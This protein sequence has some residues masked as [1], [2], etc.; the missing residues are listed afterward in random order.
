MRDF[1]AQSQVFIS[2]TLVLLTSF[3]LI[4]GGCS[5]TSGPNS[6]THPTAIRPPTS[7]WDGD[8]IRYRL[9]TH[10]LS[11]KGVP[12]KEGGYNKH[13]VDCS[14][15]VQLVFKNALGLNIPRSTNL[16]LKTGTQI[17]RQQLSVGDLVFFK[18]G[19]SKHHVG[20]Y[21]GKDQF[22]HASTSQGV[23]KS[24]LKSPY[25]S[26]HYWKATRVLSI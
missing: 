19:I 22:I 16:L 1:Q 21:I 11:W 13:G 14:G 17:S 2:V 18:T 4:T 8:S 20:I 7:Q 10:Y 25:W 26:N 24:N 3:L 15:F 23:T 9:Q 6:A 5:S 12:Y